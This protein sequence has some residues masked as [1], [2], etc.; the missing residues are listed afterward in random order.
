MSKCYIASLLFA[1][2]ICTNAS[3][4]DYLLRIETVELRDL[5]SG[6]QE[7]DSKTR[8]TVELLVHAGKGF[9]GC[10]VNGTDRVQVKG[11]LDEA[12]DGT[13]RIQ[14][15]YR[16]NS[17]SDETVPGV[18]GQRLPISNAIEMKTDV[19]SVQL[20]KAVEFDA[21]VSRS[22]KIRTTLVVH[23]FDPSRSPD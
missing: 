17:V 16:K 14:V 7:P 15:N 4:A 2:F 20:G 13:Q 18:H 9:Y 8:E 10:T 12:K 5:P 6:A 19:I 21:S 3:A 22:R 1:L 23:P 11:K